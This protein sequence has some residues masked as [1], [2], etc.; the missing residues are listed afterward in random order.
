MIKNLKY[1]FTAALLVSF[2]S[3]AIEILLIFTVRKG[4]FNLLVTIFLILSQAWLRGNESNLVLSIFLG[5]LI[6]W[7]WLSIIFI[8]F[9]AYLIFPRSVTL[10]KWRILISR[11]YLYI[12]LALAVLN[13]SVSIP[14]G[15]KHQGVLPTI[16][17]VIGSAIWFLGCFY[18]LHGLKK[19]KNDFELLIANSFLFLGIYVFFFPWLGEMP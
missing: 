11:I 12:T 7:F 5:F 18:W 4:P 1:F 17:S 13:F 6:T 14:V 15:F 16:L 10:K 19:P 8:L 9:N 3:T 2:I